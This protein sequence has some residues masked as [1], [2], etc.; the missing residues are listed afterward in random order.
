MRD[1][2]V[3]SGVAEE[4]MLLDARST[5]TFENAR[6]SARLMRAHGLAT[7]LLVSEGYHLPRARLLFRLHGVTVTAVSAAQPGSL[8][9]RTTMSLRELMTIP[10]NLVRLIVF[11]R[12]RGSR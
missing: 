2:A 12:T 7:A 4:A 8:R 5:S 3:A 9:H 6:E 10:A 11:L 1:I